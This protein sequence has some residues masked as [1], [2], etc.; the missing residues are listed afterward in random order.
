M[1]KGLGRLKNTINKYMA[2]IRPDRLTTCQSERK[3]VISRPPSVYLKCDSIVLIFCTFSSFSFRTVWRDAVMKPH[4]ESCW[5]WLRNVQLILTIVSRHKESTLPQP[6]GCVA[7]W[8]RGMWASL[9]CLMSRLIAAWQW[10]D[11]LH[12]I[13]CGSLCVPQQPSAYRMQ[14]RLIN[15]SVNFMCHSSPDL[16]ATCFHV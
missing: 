4:M 5:N 12:C 8:P 14:L 16:P 10:L 9:H 1:T 11:V 3:S 6:G 2:D 7:E 15:D 13:L